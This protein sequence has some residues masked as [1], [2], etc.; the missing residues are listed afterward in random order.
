VSPEYQQAL[1]SLTAINRQ[2]VEQGFASWAGEASLE[3]VHQN[4]A[5]E[6]ALPDPDFQSLL[7]AFAD[8]LGT[9][10]GEPRTC[11]ENACRQHKLRGGVIPP[12]HCPKLLGRVKNVEEHARA[13]ADASGGGLAFSFVKQILLNPSV[14]D[15]A[16]YLGSFLYAAP[17]GKY[18]LVWATFDDADSSNC[19][20]QRLPKTRRGIRTALGLGPLDAE[21]S[22]I[23][24]FWD[25]E[26]SGSPALHRPTVADAEAHEYYR[27]CANAAHPWGLTQPLPPNPD[28]VAP[29]PEVVMRE[30]T[31]K[32]LC[33]P[34]QVI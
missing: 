28:G 8:L 24:L 25:H 19:P 5:G 12:D 7:N 15:A 31:S 29:Q 3:Q 21:E 16:A 17:L 20:F 26:K 27:P 13:I 30:P 4:I 14:A 11:W 1:A 23:L 33:L 34:F 10:G 9:A 18:N 6:T 22:L 2:A 32:G